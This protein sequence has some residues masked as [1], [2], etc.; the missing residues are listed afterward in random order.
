M[1]LYNHARALFESAVEQHRE[2]IGKEL[3]K[4]R[5]AKALSPLESAY[6]RMAS[7]V[8]KAICRVHSAL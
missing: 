5:E 3:E 6:Y 8:R 2:A 1:K 4:I 7:A